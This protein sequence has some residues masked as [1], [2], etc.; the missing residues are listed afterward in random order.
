[1]EINTPTVREIEG[2]SSQI[3]GSIE[4]EDSPVDEANKSVWLENTT[5]LLLALIAEIKPKV[6]KC[7]KYRTKKKMYDEIRRRLEDAGHS[8]SVVQIEN[9]YRSLERRFKDAKLNNNKSG[10]AR[11]TCPYER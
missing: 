9:K 2:T 11:Q 6:G 7:T 3:L 1:M 5:K 4:N 8:Y 10:R